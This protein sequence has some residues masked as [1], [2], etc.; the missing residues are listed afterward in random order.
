MF[1]IYI[2]VFFYVLKV[3]VGIVEDLRKLETDHGFEYTTYCDVGSTAKRFDKKIIK[4]GLISL[5][6]YYFNLGNLSLYVSES[7]V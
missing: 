2:I 6:N 4:F 1:Y 3:G 7:K 5:E